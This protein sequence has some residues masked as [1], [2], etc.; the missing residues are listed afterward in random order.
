MVSGTCLLV[1]GCAGPVTQRVQIDSGA[2]AQEERNQQ[3][4]AIRTE[5]DLTKRLWTVGYGVL[6]GAA[7]ECGA[8]VRPSMGMMLVTRSRLPE[9]VRDV[10]SAALNADERVR[11]YT[12]YKGSA[13]EA[14]GIR[15]GDFLVNG[16]ALFS[17]A[18]ESREAAAQRLPADKPVAVQ[19]QRGSE[20]IGVSVVPDRV[21]DYP[22]RLMNA[23][24]VNA[25]ADGKTIN[26]TRG[27]MRFAA[28]DRELAMVIGHELGHNTMGHIDKKK[29]N[30][31]IG[32][33][34]DVLAASRGINTQ[35]A[36]MKAGAGAYSQ[37]FESEAD[38]VG[39]YYLARAG[40]D[41]EGAADF[42]RRM[43]AEHPSS[44]KGSYSATHPATTERYLALEKVNGEVKT[45]L[46]A[47]S[48]LLPNR[49]SK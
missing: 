34:F 47:G 46:S 36:F 24:E 13:A 19:V 35:S 4:V 2:R 26:I 6:K 21:C 10:A 18:N 15:T 49:I 29:G 22:L 33:I 3:M 45:K 27:M 41:T 44:I 9:K 38:Y 31:A 20:T 14:A 7:G 40:Y 39:L 28:D 1:V 30:A 8:V 48:S 11:V 42:W 23:P 25:Y 16:A 43:A 17:P 32:V 5:F 12:V 37:D